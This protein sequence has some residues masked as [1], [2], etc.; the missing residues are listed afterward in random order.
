MT[1]REISEAGGSLAETSDPF[2][3][4]DSGLTVVTSLAAP[5]P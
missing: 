1:M 2:D 3:H 5:S 4:A